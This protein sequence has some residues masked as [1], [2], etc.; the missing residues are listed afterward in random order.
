MNEVFQALLIAAF[1]PG[2]V[3]WDLTTVAGFPPSRQR[4]W[5]G[6]PAVLLVG[7]CFSQRYYCCDSNNH[8]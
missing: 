1:L 4:M 7:T 5:L 3:I 6:K 2:K 8:D